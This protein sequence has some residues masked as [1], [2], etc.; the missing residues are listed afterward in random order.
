M[1]TVQSTTTMIVPFYAR[2]KLGAR[3]DETRPYV[4]L[5]CSFSSHSETA[6]LSTECSW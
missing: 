6:I 1:S 3:S 4:M 5:F 2:L